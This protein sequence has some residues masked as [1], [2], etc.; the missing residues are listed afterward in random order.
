MPPPLNTNL[1]ILDTFILANFLKKLNLTQQ[2]Q[3]TQEQNSINY[4]RKKRTKMP[5]QNSK[6]THKN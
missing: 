2:K 5:N 1:V 6:R 4:T 3:T